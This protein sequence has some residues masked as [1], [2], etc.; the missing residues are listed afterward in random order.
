MWQASDV[1]LW[2]GRDDSLESPVAKRVFQTIKTA[3]LWRPENA[4]GKVALLGFASDAGVRRNLGRTGAAKAPPVLR[5]ALA[6]LASH[7]SCFDLMDMGDIVC[8]ADALEAA[9]SECAQ[10]VQQIHAHQGKTLII[11]GGHET[12][13]AHGSGLYEAYPNEHLAIINFDPHLDLRRHSLATSGT[14]FTQLAHLARQHNRVFDY[15]CIGASR[16]ANTAALLQDAADLNVNV[17]WDTEVHWANVASVLHTIDDTLKRADVV[18]LSVDLDVLPSYQMPSV[19]A[20][21]ALGISLDLL[22][23]L[24]TPIV[25]SGQLVGADVAEFNPEFDQCSQGA[26]VAARI[27]WHVWQNWR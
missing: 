12:A 5:Q 19:S 7:T 20:P 18:Y 17:I 26:R 6:N 22:L 13:F 3:S 4:A 10:A 1:A 14:P 2:Q 8:V 23:Y 16:A 25:I 11:G 15:T 9:Q 27:L 24:V 21:A